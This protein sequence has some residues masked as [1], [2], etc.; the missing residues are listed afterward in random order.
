[1]HAELLR[2]PTEP[3]VGPAAGK[4]DE[5]PLTRE[6]A[7]EHRSSCALSSVVEAVR[8]SVSN[9]CPRRALS[10]E[11]GRIPLRIGPAD[12]EFLQAWKAALRTLRVPGAGARLVRAGKE[13][14]A[15]DEVGLRALNDALRSAFD[16]PGRL[17]SRAAA[18]LRSRWHRGRRRRPSSSGSPAREGGRGCARP[19]SEQ[20]G[21]SSLPRGPAGLLR[22][23]FRSPAVRL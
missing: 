23:S 2:S 9:E 21:G 20:S 14:A 10:R 11:A 1:V 7:R 13:I 6:A 5:S 15:R 16:A 18:R 8:G 19:S 12:P 3:V 22:V 4:P 17:A